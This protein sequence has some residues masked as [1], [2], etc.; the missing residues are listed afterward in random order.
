MEPKLA[1]PYRKQDPRSPAY[2]VHS[3]VDTVAHDDDAEIPTGRV[4]LVTRNYKRREILHRGSPEALGRTEELGLG[5]T[6]IRHSQKG[7]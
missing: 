7:H 2:V 4:T 6:S 5:L 3:K 1:S